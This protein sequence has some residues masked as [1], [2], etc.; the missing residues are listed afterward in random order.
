VTKTREK[1]EISGLTPW[2]GLIPSQLPLRLVWLSPLLKAIGGGANFGT[3]MLFTAAAD[4][5]GEKD[6]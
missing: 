1:L 4:V 6:R 2:P 5:I 3:S